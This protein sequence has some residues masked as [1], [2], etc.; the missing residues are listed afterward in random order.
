MS[1]CFF[2]Y[3]IQKL[4]KSIWFL[5]I[6]YVILAITFGNIIIFNDFPYFPIQTSYHSLS[7]P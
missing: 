7:R 4:C 6:F 5:Y 2:V 1:C 3:F